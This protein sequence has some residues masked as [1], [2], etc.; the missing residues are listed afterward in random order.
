MVAGVPAKVVR[1]LNPE[2]PGVAAP[3]VPTPPASEPEPSTVGSLPRW[4]AREGAS[5]RRHRWGV[6]RRKG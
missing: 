6:Y 5:A 3:S 4:P 2:G 1:A